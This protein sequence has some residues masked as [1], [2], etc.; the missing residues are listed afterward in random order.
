MLGE[1][2]L[3]EAALRVAI[4]L[5]P[6]LTALDAIGPYEVLTR[7][8]GARVVFTSRMPG[9][10]RTSDGRLALTA[11]FA[12]HQMA[13]PEVVVVPGGPGARDA[14]DHVEVAQWL[15]DAHE[16]SLWTTSVCTGSLLLA[17]ANILTGVPATTHYAA[18]DLL[19]DLGAVPVAERVVRCGKV[20]TA[21]GVSAGID[22]A[23]QLAALI[24]GEDIAKAI[25]LIIEY[26]PQPPFDAGSPQKAGADIRRLAAT[27]G[28][29]QQR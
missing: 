10:V 11:D 13:S 28:S 8:P 14:L 1:I 2:H 16:T 27:L 26:D 5:F 19:R 20:I 23:L 3:I 24:A 21:A 6:G 9:P 18:V 17:G 4:L 15:R 22:M 12:L 29:G 7:V 25:Q